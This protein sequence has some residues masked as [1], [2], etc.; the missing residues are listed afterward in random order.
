MNNFKSP[1]RL[2]LYGLEFSDVSFSQTVDLITNY[3]F[4]KPNYICFPSTNIVAKIHKNNY[5]KDVF[6]KSF[7]TLADGKFTEYYFRVKGNKNIE[8]ISGYWLLKDLLNTGLN[9][10][11]YGGDTT[12]LNKLKTNIES[13]FPNAKVLGYSSPPF[14]AIDEIKSSQQ[15]KNDI[16]HINILK[17]DLIW[18]GISNLK[19]DVLMHHFVN[20]L[21]QG[22]MLGVGA[23]FLYMSGEVKKGPEWIK[24]LG[25]RWVIRVIQEPRKEWK[26]TVP[27][28]LLFIKLFLTEIIK[29]PFRKK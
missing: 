4:N 7:L 10:Y 17:P 25:L 29:Y 20:E 8:N 16:V 23:V 26:K 2:N 15:I 1:D 18:I 28:V 24:K 11:F 12:T 22:L 13:D 6:N 14:V 21:D 3:G 27:S 19:Q 5:L 9:H